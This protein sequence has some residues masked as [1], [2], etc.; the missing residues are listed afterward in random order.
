L[1]YREELLLGILQSIGSGERQKRFE[2]MVM[3]QSEGR[4]ED[5]YSVFTAC[6]RPKD[7]GTTTRNR[8][9]AKSKQDEVNPQLTLSEA[10]RPTERLGCLS[11]DT[12]KPRQV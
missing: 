8:R 9:E 11:E 3:S 1:P 6:K 5:S 2:E 12:L 4:D 7:E 10:P